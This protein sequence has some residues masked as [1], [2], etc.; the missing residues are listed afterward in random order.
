MRETEGKE[1]AS[2]T[3]LQSIC[4]LV[5]AENLLYRPF[6]E[7]FVERNAPRLSTAIHNS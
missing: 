5:E 4:L 6:C 1:M 3:A 2:F 7:L